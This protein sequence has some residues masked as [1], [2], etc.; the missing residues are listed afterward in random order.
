MKELAFSHFWYW[1]ILM[2]AL[3]YLIGCFNFAVIIAKIKHK[4]VHKIGSG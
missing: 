1:L 3:C 2:A 4:D